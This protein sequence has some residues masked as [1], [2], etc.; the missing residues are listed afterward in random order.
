M[1]KRIWLVWAKQLMLGLA[2]AFVCGLLWDKFINEPYARSGLWSGFVAVLVYVFASF[3]ISFIQFLSG[4]AYLKLFAG[5]DLSGAIL[6]EFR[7]AKMPA[8][9]EYQ[10]KNF[11]YL[12]ELADDPSEDPGDRVKAAII[13]GSYKTAMGAGIIRALIVRAA[14]D[15]AILRYSLEAPT[16]TRDGPR[17]GSSLASQS[18]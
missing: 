11:D 13:F 7:A 17:R 10:A 1:G 12:A 6:D 3:A 8:P 9:R 18:Y 4:L 2:V 5:K 14:L 16:G 15:D